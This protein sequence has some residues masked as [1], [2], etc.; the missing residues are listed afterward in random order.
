[1]TF[2]PRGPSRRTLQASRNACSSGIPLRGV[3]EN[4]QVP[5]ALQQ[6]IGSEIPT[7]LRFEAPIRF[8]APAMTTTIRDLFRIDLPIVQAPMAGVQLAA[9]AIAVTDAGGLGSLPG[10]MLTPETLR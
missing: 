5:I 6:C 7:V 10:A 9:L 8:E 4:W 3:D 2:S 1:M